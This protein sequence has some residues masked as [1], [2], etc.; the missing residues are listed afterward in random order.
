MKIIS[1]TGHRP[2]KVGGYDANSPLRRAVRAQLGKE[3]AGAKEKFGEIGVISGGALAVDTD[4]AWE[5]HQLAVPYIIAAPCR[6]QDSRWP[7]TSKDRYKRMCEG[8]S[9]D[10]LIEILGDDQLGERQAIDERMGGVFYVYDGN[11]PGAWC[12]QTRNEWMVDHSDFT[13]A[14][15][16]RV[17]AG[18]T[19]NCVRYARENA[20]PIKYI[21]PT[22]LLEV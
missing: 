16:D 11:Y 15:W 1:L 5:A 22:T 13:L 4:G 19:W 9:P 14:V 8:A 17:E 3:L 18:G 2:P 6:N 20:Q 21:N 12:M 10:L 7:Q